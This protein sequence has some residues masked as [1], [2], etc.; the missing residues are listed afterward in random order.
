MQFNYNPY[1]S[2][3][4]R[5]FNP[6][7][8]RLKFPVLLSFFLFFN[9]DYDSDVDYDMFHVTVNSTVQPAV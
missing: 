8:R 1:F 2:R 3:F 5:H 7:N 6:V 4:L 9:D